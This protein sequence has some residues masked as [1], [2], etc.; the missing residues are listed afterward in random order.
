MPYLA[1]IDP[2]GYKFNDR[3]STTINHGMPLNKVTTAVIARVMLFVNTYLPLSAYR[4][5]DQG[6]P[7]QYGNES[8]S[9]SEDKTPSHYLMNNEIIL[10]EPARMLHEQIQS[11]GLEEGNF[12]GFIANLKETLMNETSIREKIRRRTL[13]TYVTLAS[14]GIGALLVSIVAIFITPSI[15]RNISIVLIPISIG[16]LASLTMDYRMRGYKYVKF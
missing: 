8:L 10:T 5:L 2:R 11:W 9:F 7:T 3:S 6:C 12:I 14:L 13:I 16:Y 4:P 15:D 1:V